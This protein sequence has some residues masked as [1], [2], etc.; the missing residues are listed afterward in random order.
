MT[1]FVA[2]LVL[3]PTLVLT[4]YIGDRTNLEKAIAYTEQ[5]I[6]VNGE[7]IDLG[8]LE[9]ALENADAVEEKDRF[10][11]MSVADNTPILS[12]VYAHLVLDS[13]ILAND[14]L[15]NLRKVF[16]GELVDQGFSDGLTTDMQMP[17]VKLKDI[18]TQTTFD[19]TSGVY[20]TWV[21]M[22]LQG[23]ENGWNE[24]YVTEFAL[25]EGAYIS[26]YYLDVFGTKKMGI[27]ADRRAAMW[28]YNDIVVETPAQDPGLLHYTGDRTIE[29]RVY[30]FNSDEPRYTGFEIIHSEAAAIRIDGEEVLLSAPPQT[31]VKEMEHAV[32]IPGAVKDGLPMAEGRPNRY[33]FII[34][35]SKDSDIED[36]LSR[37]QDYAQGSGISDA[38][39]VFTSY[40]TDTYRLPDA[41]SVDITP[42]S[43][44]N[45]ALAVKS[46]LMQNGNDSVPI[47][48]YTSG[49]PALALIPKNV[50]VLAAQYPESAYYYRLN[51]DETLS[52]CDFETGKDVGKMDEPLITKARLYNGV[53]VRDDDQTQILPDDSVD[54]TEISGSEYEQAVMLD[55]AA[56]YGAAQE[57][58][59]SLKLLRASF[60][61]GILTPQTAFM[62]VETPAQEAALYEKQQ[63]LIKED[64]ELIKAQDA[65]KSLD[66]PS[67]LVCVLVALLGFALVKQR[68]RK[69]ALNRTE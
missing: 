13:R 32:L 11:N 53:R 69:N 3:L 25:P 27:L 22:T 36:Q 67:A 37:V 26:D 64:K 55:L 38:T 7:L 19:D 17:Q 66:E 68:K 8:R 29:L 58:A 40:K 49:N 16:F 48:I 6:S 23:P 30:P 14:R 31:R 21:N 51:A 54:F 61:A 20:R 47:I 57:A 50:S 28:L 43:G 2:G 56:K 62:V 1:V 45:L 34:D 24:E 46:I 42:Q 52:G 12:S 39:V 18:S 9:R 44:F 63:Q 41:D 35:C 10:F 5:D 60:K 65:A 33:Y 4:S 15:E 59:A